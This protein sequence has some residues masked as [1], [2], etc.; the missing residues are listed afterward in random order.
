MSYFLDSNGDPKIGKLLA[1]VFLVLFLVI[2]VFASLP[3]GTVPEGERGIRLRLKA[4]TGEVLN[5]GVYLRIPFIER[6][7]RVNVQTEKLEIESSQAYSHD[8]QVVTVHS[9]L[10]YNVDPNSVINVYRQYN[11]DYEG[12]LV[13]PKMEAAIKQVIAQYSAEELLNKRGEVS[14]KINDL[15]QATV[16]REF[17]NLNYALVNEDFSPEFEKAIEQKQVAQQQAEK[18]TND[19]KRI[20][21]EAEQKIETAKADAESIRIQAEAIT[22]QGGAE[23]VRLKATEKWDGKLPQ[24]M[25]PGSTVPFLNLNQ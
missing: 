22:S 1:H 10:N 21:I 8:L 23:Y 13:R 19:L 14:A 9:V 24:Q 11:L 25:I 2:F 12:K 6:V 16:P 4:A 7:Q 3:F 15:V 20:K 18:A 17:I 5:P